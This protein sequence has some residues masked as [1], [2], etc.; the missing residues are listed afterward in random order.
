MQNM[1][2]RGYD[3]FTK[4]CADGRHTTQDEIKKIAE[5]RVWLGKDA[6]ELGLIDELGNID[7]AI[8]KAATLAGLTDWK[9]VSYPARKDPFTELIE[10]LSEPDSEEAR[11]VAKIK[12]FASQP[13]IMALMPEIEIK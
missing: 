8:A 11:I 10:S 2:N 5:G 1:V 12:A 4:R 7:A 3:L 6:L 13:R 9:V